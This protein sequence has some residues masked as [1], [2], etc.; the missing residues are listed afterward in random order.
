MSVLIKQKDAEDILQDLKNIYD[1][2]FSMKTYLMMG[3]T[4]EPLSADIEQNFLEVK[5]H[6]SKYLRVLAEKIDPHQFRYDPEK[7]IQLLRQAISVT[8]LRGLPTADK[9][10]LFDLW[11]EVYIHLSQVLGAFLFITEGYQPKKKEKKTTSIASLKKGASGTQKKKSNTGKVVV[12]VVIIV[13]VVL[14]YFL[15]K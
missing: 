6:T 11:H 3:F 15:R 13:I 1:L 10:N 14:I 9:K 4:D 12:T 5:S 7:M 2:W 8:H